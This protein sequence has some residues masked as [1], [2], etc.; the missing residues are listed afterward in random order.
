MGPEPDCSQAG[1]TT[2]VEPISASGSGSR[3]TFN[4]SAGPGVVMQEYAGT[5]GMNHAARQHNFRERPVP[6]PP[7]ERYRADTNGLEK[8]Q[9]I[10]DK[11][12]F[13]HSRDDEKEKNQALKKSH[14]HPPQPA[15]LT[16]GNTEV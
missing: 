15:G 13:H 2:P 11:T 6:G 16:S 4:P 7:Q 10:V 12:S 14:Y 3:T 5:R 9:N 8:Q 1:R